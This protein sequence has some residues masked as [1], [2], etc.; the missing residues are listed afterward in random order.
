M[1]VPEDEG[2]G[3]DAGTRCCDACLSAVADEWTWV[4]GLG[5]AIDGWRFPRSI[6]VGFLSSSFWLGVEMTS[7]SRSSV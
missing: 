6:S 4:A 3:N 1:T 2:G 5:G 7:D